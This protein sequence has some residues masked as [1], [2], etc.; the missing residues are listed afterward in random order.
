MVE[1]RSFKAPVRPLT[2][3]AGGSIREAATWGNG[4]RAGLAGRGTWECYARKLIGRCE[5]SGKRPEGDTP[6]ELM[7]IPLGIVKWS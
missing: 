6:P 2:G 1:Y 3:G 5:A 7:T 4:K